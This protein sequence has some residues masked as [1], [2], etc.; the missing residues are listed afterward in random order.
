MLQDGGFVFCGECFGFGYE[1]CLSFFV[2]FGRSCGT[3]GDRDAHLREEFFLARGRA[4]AE[5]ARRFFA[6]VAELVWGVGGM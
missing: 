1:L 5:E 2:E 3:G 6:G 4:N